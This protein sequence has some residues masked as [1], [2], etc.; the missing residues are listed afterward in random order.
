MDHRTSLLPAD[1][2][3][4][5][6]QDECQ[7]KQYLQFPAGTPMSKPCTNAG[8]WDRGYGKDSECHETDIPHRQGGQTS[9]THAMYD[10]CS[11]CTG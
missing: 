11:Y 3:H 10:I 7:G 6:D 8:E 2:H 9:Y 5:A 4:P 1:K